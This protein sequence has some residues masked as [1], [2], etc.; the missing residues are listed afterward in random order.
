MSSRERSSVPLPT[1]DV[2]GT[3]DPSRSSAARRSP[4]TSRRSFIGIPATWTSWSLSPSRNTP[5]RS[6][7]SLD[8]LR[9]GRNTSGEAL[10]AFGSTSFPRGRDRMPGC[11]YGQGAGT[12]RTCSGFITRSNASSNSKRMACPFPWRLLQ[13][14]R[15]AHVLVFLAVAQ[16]PSHRTHTYA[17]LIGARHLDRKREEDRLRSRLA[18]FRAGLE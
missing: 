3:T 14:L 8:G 7:G 11:W 13:C 17:R 1:F 12:A 6:R 16:D 15:Y 4:S 5:K 2:T 9:V 18:A 10:K